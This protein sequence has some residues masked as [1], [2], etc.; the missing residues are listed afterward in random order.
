[1]I[2]IGGWCVIKPI[3]VTNTYTH[4]IRFLSARV[5]NSVKF[6]FNHHITIFIHQTK[7][8]IIRK[9]D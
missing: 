4:N 6:G 1:M 8:L 3:R 7:M 9:W 5:N 2:S